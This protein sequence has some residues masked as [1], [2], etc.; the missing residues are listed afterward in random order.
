[1]N[2]DETAAP[3]AP[4]T[5]LG[6]TSDPDP[7]WG[8]AHLVRCPVCGEDVVDGARFC[9]RCGQ[10]LTVEEGS[11]LDPLLTALPEKLISALPC[12]AC[13]GRIA[14]D[15][16]CELCGEPAVSPRDHW[17]ETPA[18]WVAGVCDRGVR[19][20]R[21]ED[22]MSLLATD[23]PGSFAA[24]VVCDGVS[25]ATDSDVA[26]KAAAQAA[27]EA[28][29]ERRPVG[30][31]PITGS[32][33]ERM[34]AWSAQMSVAAK[35]ANAA[36]VDTSAEYDEQA[37]PPSCTFVAAVVDGPL[38]ITG[39]I[40]DSRVYWV[41]DEGRP[42]QL[43]VDDSWAQEMVDRGMS[44]AA[45]ETA[46]QAHAITRWL[47]PDAPDIDAHTDIT[48]P[49][50]DG[51]IVVCSDGLWNYCSRPDEI[52]ATLHDIQA[53]VGPEPVAL[54]RGLVDWANAQGGRDNVTVALARIT[55]SSTELPTDPKESHG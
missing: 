48:F 38:V 40:G 43:S 2:L 42:E 55:P 25:T 34:A 18:S 14:A 10:P 39:W 5:L 11:R 4:L 50:R 6:A 9:E 36:I 41:P 44:R 35:R 26:S 31:D 21:N 52:A 3:P 8:S 19:H 53:G 32:V 23:P 12:A 37:S 24:I 28:L 30:A 47:G 33:T 22:A 54:C 46:P 16:Y 45:A 15:G 7:A 49:D 1:M 13:G 17:Q 51:W 27:L 29:G 20:H